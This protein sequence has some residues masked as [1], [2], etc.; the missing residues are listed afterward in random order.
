M[1]ECGEWFF[2]AGVGFIFFSYN[3]RHSCDFLPKIVCI[4]DEA[5]PSSALEMCAVLCEYLSGSSKPMEMC[6]KLSCTSHFWCA[7]WALPT[8]QMK[9]YHNSIIE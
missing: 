9:N 8:L 1:N 7:R 3:A 4:R 2:T 5:K 6:Q